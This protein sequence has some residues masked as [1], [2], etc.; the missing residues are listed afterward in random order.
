MIWKQPEM[1]TVIDKPI[2]DTPCVDCG[3]TAYICVDRNM[4][5]QLCGKKGG[6]YPEYVGLI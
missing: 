6:T 4:F 5:C 2:Y 1:L 3:S